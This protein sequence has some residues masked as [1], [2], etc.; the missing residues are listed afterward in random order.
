MCNCLSDYYQTNKTIQ[1]LLHTIQCN[2]LAFTWVTFHP[3]H[4]TPPLLLPTPKLTLPLLA[5]N[6]T[7]QPPTTPL[8]LSPNQ[9]V[10]TLTLVTLLSS[11]QRPQVV[12]I[13]S[14]CVAR[15]HPGVIRSATG[16]MA[17]GES[18]VLSPGVPGNPTLY[19]VA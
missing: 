11:F 9:L 14:G 8:S 1:L 18:W 2:A 16:W 15:L 19:T 3:P 4:T 17:G 12:G 7:I 10:T 13:R 6:T 5:L